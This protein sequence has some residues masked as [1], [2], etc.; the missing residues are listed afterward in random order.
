MEPEGSLPHSQ[1]P[2]SVPILRQLDPVHSPTSHFLK[3][4]LNIIFPLTAGSPKWSLSP[5]FP[6]QKPVRPSPLPHTRYLPRPSHSSR[7]YHP[8]D[9]GWAVQ[10]I[11]FL[12]TE[13]STFPCYL[14]PLGPKYSPL[15]P[16]LRH[17][18]LTFLPQCQRRSFTPVQNNRQNYRSVY[19]N[20]YFFE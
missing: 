10:N 8:H 3:I 11:K 13:F 9:M 16:I 14:I 17:P 5:R 1:V 18:Q 15:H 19:L 4:H 6:H 2:P 12:I 20:L 7:F